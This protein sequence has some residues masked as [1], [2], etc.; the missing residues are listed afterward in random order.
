MR[1]T[2]LETLV[3]GTAWRN[4]TFVKLHTD[5]G[6]IGLGESR[7]SNRTE[8]LLAYLEAITP[9]YLVGADPFEI[10]K[11]V[12]TIFYGDS[13]RVGEI[14][15]TA[16]AVVE[17]ACW[18]LMGK[19]LNVPVYRLLGG[20][21]RDRIKA[22]ANGWYTVD[23]QPEAF[24][25]AAQGAVAKGYHAL[26]LDP[27]GTSHQ[28]ITRAE[29]H[30]VVRICEAVRAAVGPDVELFIEM[31]GRFGPAEAVRV[32]NA[33]ERIEPGWLEEPT[34]PDNLKAFAH[35]ARQMRSPVATGEKLHHRFEF[36]ELFEYQACDIIQPDVTHC[37]GLAEVKTLA[38]MADVH[39]MLVAP[40]NVAGPVATAA[41]LHL[42]ATIPNFK[43]QETFNDFAAEEILRGGPDAGQIGNPVKA[44]ASGC[45][46]VV[47]GAFPLPQGPGLGVTLDEDLIHAHPMQEGHFSLFTPDWHKRQASSS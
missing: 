26:K 38:A 34:P 13:G 1:I 15:G 5:E 22:Y 12:H 28:T 41:N 23:R 10:N 42:A 21:V 45:P 20:A 9:R 27:F 43:I 11:L 6:L 18:D 44:A 2:K 24:A 36:R 14:V 17:M 31:H 33:L 40:H 32:A 3:L 39:G 25:K 7:L 37:C 46:D 30:E 16:I 35:A 19:A 29:L 47:D 8:P 4:L